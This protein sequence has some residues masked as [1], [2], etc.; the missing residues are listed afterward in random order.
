MHKVIF[1]YLINNLFITILIID[2][3]SIISL[4]IYQIYDQ[5]QEIDNHAIGVSSYIIHIISALVLFFYLFIATLPVYLNLIEKVRKNDLFSFL[6]F[7]M[8]PFIQ[9]FLILYLKDF[10]LII[11]IICLVSSMIYINFYYRFRKILMF[12]KQ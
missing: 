11:I 3:F 6:S 1:K 10:S 5:D 7:F 4:S 9:C 2:L 12:K 8:V